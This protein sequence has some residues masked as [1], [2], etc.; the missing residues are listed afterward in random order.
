M[1]KMNYEKANV[2]AKGRHGFVF[3]RSE[4]DQNKEH[5]VQIIHT[6]AL[7]AAVKAKLGYCVKPGISI[8]TILSEY[9]DSMGLFRLDDE[10]ENHYVFRH[11]KFINRVACKK[12]KTGLKTIANKQG[13]KNYGITGKENKHLYNGEKP[14]W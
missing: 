11:S 2:K 7:Y 12:Q 14:P 4:I 10:A 3:D 9:L 8:Y 6:K 5:K 13:A 1:A